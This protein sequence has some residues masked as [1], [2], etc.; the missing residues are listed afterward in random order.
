MREVH[1]F[2][3]LLIFFI[4]CSRKV[5]TYD[6]N[7]VEN[8]EFKKEFFSNVE[9]VEKKIFTI[10]DSSFRNS[11]K[12]LFKY[13]HVSF[14]QMLNY[15][16]SYPSDAFEKDKKQWLIWYENNKCNNIQIKN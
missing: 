3:M 9:N 12:F 4:S 8:L 1:V 6:I 11:L 7:C 15:G 10:Q 16:R 13:A 2:L 5:N 14:E